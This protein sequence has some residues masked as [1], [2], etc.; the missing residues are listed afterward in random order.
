MPEKYPLVFEPVLLGVEQVGSGTYKN[1]SGNGRV[2]QVFLVPDLSLQI[3]NTFQ[4]LAQ[5]N[6]TKV[7]IVI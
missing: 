6:T 1:V 2:G 4:I 3:E 5:Y 7:Y